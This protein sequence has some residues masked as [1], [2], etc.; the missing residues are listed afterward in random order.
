MIFNLLGSLGL[1]LLGMW[2]MTEGLKLAGGRALGTLLGSWTSS[3]YRG[4]ASGILIT[5]MVQSSSAVTVATIGFVNAGLM[6]FQRALWVVFGS[7]VGTTATAWI[8][9]FFGFSV[10]LND[11]TFPLVGIGAALRIFSPYARGKALGMALAGFGLLFM[12]IDGL[13]E[14]FAGHAQQ[15]DAE[16]LLTASSFP[17][18]WALAIG[19][20]LT[21]L[22][23]SSSAATAIILTAVGSGVA[24]IEAA[25]AVIGSSIG[26]TS[27]AL[28]ASIGATPNAK[29][30]AWAHVIFNGL[31]GAAALLVLPLFWALFNAYADLSRMAASAIVWLA[32]FH[33]FYKVL[34]VLLMWP[35]EPHLSR[36]LLSRYQ[37]P[38]TTLGAETHL[39]ANVA[40]IPDL[41]LRAVA[42]ELE[43]LMESTGQLSMQ[44]G[45][46]PDGPYY[47]REI[48]RELSTLKARV[49]RVNHFIALSLKSTMTREQ[50]ELLS[51]GLSV[52]H[53]LNYA[54]TTFLEVLE[55]YDAIAQSP[56]AESES[57]RR[58]FT[59]INEFNHG[60]HHDE[61]PVQRERLAELT[62]FYR[63]VKTQ[64]LTAPVHEKMD[65]DAVDT[66][67]QMA[68][69]GRRFIEQ[70][71]QAKEAYQA[72]ADAV[73]RK[74]SA[75]ENG[76]DNDDATAQHPIKDDRE[77]AANE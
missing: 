52:S 32:V 30:L 71:L 43:A 38:R 59:A 25:A 76:N 18:L 4:L 21:L 9:T 5:A 66:A 14:G 58:W 12:G 22:T 54:Y 3:R 8:V 40:T 56:V 49:G 16:L 62:E 51:V 31:T 29:R 63:A 13:K 46:K 36:W 75:N 77:Y 44:L 19:F 24:G 34:G 42:L 7:N 1:F 41:A 69:Q 17:I 70:V 48:H 67:L 68:S 65:V 6:N 73:F 11:F 37:E 15:I 53:H 35:L 23:Q 72:L 28:I 26:T 27:T 39:D 2:L 55:R 33:T 47:K 50:G 64:L 10:S 61:A 60:I 45:G 74:V 57:L 20:I